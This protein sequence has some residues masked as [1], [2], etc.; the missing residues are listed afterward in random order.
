MI[1]GID[2]SNL[3]GGTRTHLIEVLNAANPA[4]H[5]IERVVVWAE[6]A[7]LAQLVDRDW[8]V[9]QPP[10]FI[11]KGWV[12]RTLWQRFRLS[13]EARNAACSLLLV[14]GGAYAGS[15]RP[16]VTMSQN[17]LPFEWR[18]LRRFGVS[19][20][21][22]KLLLLRFVQ[23][24]ALRKADGAVFLTSYSRDA[25]LKVTGGLAGRTIV[26]PHGLS[27]RFR[28][29]PGDQIGKRLYS[30]VDPCRILYV[31][32]IDMY[33]HQWHV[34]EAVAQLRKSTG[35]PLALDLVGGAYL[36][37][38]RRLRKV[39]ERFDPEG[40][41]AH[42]HG[43]IPY[44][45]VHEIYTRADVSV[46]ASSC[47]NLPVILLESMGAGLPIACSN[48]GV[49]PNVLG[50]R[51]EYFDPE[52]PEEIADALRR[53]I[54]EPES[55][56]TLAESCYLAAQ[57]YDWKRCADETFAFLADVGKQYWQWHDAN[58]R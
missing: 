54:E 25:V 14:P 20:M 21:A 45:A 5:G 52:N 33:K 55:R 1:I 34:V 10:H 18:E 7:T 48:R 31:S 6:R 17:L 40:E 19:R 16:F 47:E 43:L 37:A 38:L 46:F 51:G 53:L 3:S 36:P 44:E 4:N 56:R 32:T 58:I 35:L 13:E 12:C 30:I 41:W 26:I 29:K 9:K 39:M 57:T 15:F 42:Y 22:G 11:E 8:L 28:K 50:E 23:A 24:K 2:A 27:K 49:M